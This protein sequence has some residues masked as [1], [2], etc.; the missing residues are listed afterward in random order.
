MTTDWFWEGNVVAAVVAHLR[1]NGWTVEF[2]AD[3]ATRARGVDIRARRDETT[4]LI[5]A[6]GY[7]STLYARGDSAGLPKKTK[8]ATQAP[9]WFGSAL[10]TAVLCQT[11]YPSAQVALAFPKFP[12][13][14]KLIEKTRA[15]LIKLGV[16]I[17]LV[18][19]NG[20]VENMMLEQAMENDD[21]G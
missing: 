16:D 20:L 6:K 5:E 11:K 8:P 14:V 21:N 9:N 1:Q 10:L 7:P 12:L 2:V 13:Y 3:T 4:L 19:E 18:S 15:A 17:Y